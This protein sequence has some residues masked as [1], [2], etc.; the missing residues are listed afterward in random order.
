MQLNHPPLYLASKSPRR[1]ELLTAAG[2]PFQLIDVDVEETYPD[3]MVVED[4]PE[5]LA[6]KCRMP[7]TFT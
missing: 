3:D 7:P 4:V 1:Q 2:I 6:R 5:F